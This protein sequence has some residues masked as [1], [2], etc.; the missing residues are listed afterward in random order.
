VH[1]LCE[2]AGIRDKRK[3]REMNTEKMY[4]FEFT[5]EEL[6]YLL[7][8]LNNEQYTSNTN[9][10]LAESLSNTIH[11]GIDVN[12]RLDADSIKVQS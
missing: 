11:M 1:G 3:S 2:R 10:T 6:S 5:K 9:A 8:L 12:D 7:E 4:Q